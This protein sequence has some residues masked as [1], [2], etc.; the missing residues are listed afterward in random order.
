M[1]KLIANALGL[2]NGVLAVAITVITGLIG[3]PLFFVVGFLAAVLI[4]GSI[5]ILVTI[6]GEL[7]EIKEK[8]GNLKQEK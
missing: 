4:C 1:N 5:A 6:L 8:L 2:V 3:G 7:E